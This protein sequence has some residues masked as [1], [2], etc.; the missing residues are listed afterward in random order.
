MTKRLREKNKRK[1]S[2]A[3]SF[4]KDYELDSWGD[5]RPLQ[6]PGEEDKSVIK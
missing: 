2:R 3:Y 1:S 4:L 5:M 6:G